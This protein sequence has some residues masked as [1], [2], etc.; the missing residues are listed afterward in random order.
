MCWAIAVWLA[1]KAEVENGAEGV[2]IEKHNTAISIGNCS[3]ADSAA[4]LKALEMHRNSMAYT[5]KAA[6][7]EKN[8][9]SRNIVARHLSRGKIS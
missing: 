7:L 3:S 6:L 5:E 9:G 1:R 8:H 4:T 2:V